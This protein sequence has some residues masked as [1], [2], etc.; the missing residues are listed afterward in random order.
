MITLEPCPRAD[1]QATLEQ[2]PHHWHSINGTIYTERHP[3]GHPYCSKD[4][5]CY[6]AHIPGGDGRDYLSDPAH[7]P[8]Y[9]TRLRNAL[10]DANDAWVAYLSILNESDAPE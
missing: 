9:D 2:A 8:D 6:S 5:L 7:I 3:V 10:R 1:C 4:P